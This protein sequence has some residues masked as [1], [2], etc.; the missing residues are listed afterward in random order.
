MKHM[1]YHGEPAIMHSYRDISEPYDK[2]LRITQNRKVA[3][4]YPMV[5]SSAKK[6]EYK[7]MTQP[8]TSATVTLNWSWYHII[9]NNIR[10]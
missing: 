3:K 10:S 7:I 5:L 2:T 6:Y 1:S 4:Q 8:S 9:I